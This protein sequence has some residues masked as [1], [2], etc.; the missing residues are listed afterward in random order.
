MLVD[1][2]TGGVDHDDLAFEGGG[3]RSEQPVPH[4][5]FTPAD[6]P[7][8]AGGRGAVALGYLGPRRAGAEPPCATKRPKALL[9]AGRNF[10]LR[11]RALPVRPPALTR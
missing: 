10:E 3:N 8:V 6:E 5:G 1:A 2:D 4:P 9:V 11:P 7:V